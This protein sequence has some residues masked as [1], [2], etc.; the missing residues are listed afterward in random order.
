MGISS[1][2]SSDSLRRIMPL[3]GR[4]LTSLKSNPFAQDIRSIIDNYKVLGT[5]SRA[6]LVAEAAR[7]ANDREPGTRKN[8]MLIA[9]GAV[10]I[11]PVT[12]PSVA[13]PL[14]ET[15]GDQKRLLKY[16]GGSLGPRPRLSLRECQR[17]FLHDPLETDASWWR[18]PRTGYA[19]DRRGWDHNKWRLLR[20]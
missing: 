2:I 10:V 17:M 15:K 8:E 14:G 5:K 3:L 13:A 19:N 9:I 7:L 16:S 12:A 11:Y 4:F 6:R 18:R 1:E 20:N